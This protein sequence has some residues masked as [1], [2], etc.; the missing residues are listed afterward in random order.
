M[1][2]T[3][4]LKRPCSICRRW[5]L[6]DVRQNGRQTT[7]SAECRKA[8]H[9]RQC[10][11]WNRKNKSYFKSIYLSRKLER[12]TQSC[13]AKPPPKGSAAAS[14]VEKKGILPPA[15]RLNLHLPYDVME[16]EIGRRCL[17]TVEYLIEQVIQQ[18]R[19]NAATFPWRTTTCQEM[20]Q[21]FQDAS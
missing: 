6:P 11:R 13:L 18:P 12:F 4:P 3:K 14:I 20:P 10:E 21:G 5:F 15:S 16:A 17:I 2:N 8:R 19:A 9:R 1:P 7:C